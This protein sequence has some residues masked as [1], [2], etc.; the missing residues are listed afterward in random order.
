MQRPG[1]QRHRPVDAAQPVTGAE[2]PHLGELGAAADPGAAVLADQAHRVGER[3]PRREQ[4]RRGHRRDAL[5]ALHRPGPGEAGE[6]AEAR[7]PARGRAAAPPSAR[8]APAPPRDGQA[9][10][11]PDAAAATWPC[12]GVVVVHRSPGRWPTTS[13]RPGTESHVDP[14]GEGVALVG[15]LGAEPARHRRGRRGR[16]KSAHTTSA[17]SGTPST[18][19]SPRPPTAAAIS[20]TTPIAVARPSA[21][22][23][24]QADVTTGAPR[25]AASARCAAGRR[26]CCATRSRSST[27][28]AGRRP[29]ARARRGRSP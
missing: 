29:G 12:S 26:R 1:A 9:P 11:G 16:V 27:A 23:G 6:V 3:G 19:R 4:P 22:V 2:L 8:C 7:P 24:R 10:A 13:R 28:R 21:R 17:T 14:P 15:H 18:A 25:C 20:I 5:G